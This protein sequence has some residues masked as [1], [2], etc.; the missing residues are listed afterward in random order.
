MA[1]DFEV[2]EVL[3]VQGL[4]RDR[5]LSSHGQLLQNQALFENV[6]MR[7]TFKS[8]NGKV[9]TVKNAIFEKLTLI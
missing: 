7:K 3:D 1:G 9:L 6:S 4:S 5:A 8:Q 2:Y